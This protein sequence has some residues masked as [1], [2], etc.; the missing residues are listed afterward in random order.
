MRF[1]K[2]F[3]VFR[4]P[5]ILKLRFIDTV[6]TKFGQPFYKIPRIKYSSK[7]ILNH[8]SIGDISA[9]EASD[10]EKMIADRFLERKYAVLGDKWISYSEE[11]E[12]KKIKWQYDY[13]SNYYSILFSFFE[14][15]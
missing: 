4:A 7:T 9:Y 1:V 8:C 6:F 10:L 11:Q 3:S 5:S 14:V 2:Y 15:S 13:K 12:G